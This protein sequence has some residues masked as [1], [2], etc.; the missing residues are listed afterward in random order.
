MGKNA[1]L[2]VRLH[3]Q[4]REWLLSLG[5]GN[6]V[7]GVRNLVQQA[8]EKQFIRDNLRGKSGKTNL[9]GHKSR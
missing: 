7:E 5:N 2:A 3:S 8:K 6:I 1:K 4:E 9:W